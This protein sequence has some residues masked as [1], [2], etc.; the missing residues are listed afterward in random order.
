MPATVAASAET[1]FVSVML[2]FVIIA[3]ND[4]VP[5]NKTPVKEKAPVVVKFNVN[6][7]RTDEFDIV[8]SVVFAAAP[9]ICSMTELIDAPLTATLA[10][11]VI[12]AASV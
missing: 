2:T 12:P 1:V 3:F 7:S 11:M 6:E 10:G 8:T 4:V 9:V 5:E